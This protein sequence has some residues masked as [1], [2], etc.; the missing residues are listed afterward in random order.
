MSPKFRRLQ[1]MEGDDN[2]RAWRSHAIKKRKARDGFGA[3]HVKAKDADDGKFLVL[4]QARERML[5]EDPKRSGQED[6]T[7][8]QLPRLLLLAASAIDADHADA[9]IDA[10]VDLY[11]HASLHGHPMQR[12]MAYF[13]DGL[14]ARILTDSSPFYRSIMAHPTPEEE[15][16]A[17]TELYRASPCYQFAHFTANQTIV[18]AFEAE[19]KQNGRRLYV[20]DFD[21]SYGFQ[22]PSLIQSLCDKATTSKP[23]SL[24]LTGFGRST[25][26][27]KNTETRLVGFS[28]SCSNLEFV[29]NGLLRG[30]TTSDLKI[31]KNA[32]L[33]VNLVFY[34]QTMKSSSEMLATLMSIHSLNPSVVV[35]AEK[36]ISQRPAGY[37]AR[38][39][40]SSLNYFA[41]MFRSLHD[42]LPADSLGRL[43]IEKNHLGREI[44]SAIT[45]NCEMTSAWKGRMESTGF[46]GMKLSSRSVSQAKLLLKI[47][48]QFSSIEHVSNSGFG[49]SETDDGRTLS[50]CLQDRNL[51][52]VSA[53]KC[54][55]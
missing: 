16:T 54:T 35:L 12:V 21:V 26:E 17:F 7:D 49:I 31:E 13:A 36:E 32:T 28:K 2:V 43:S 27:L 42:C 34:L 55:R 39:V 23:I 25:E 10:I 45:C 40:E 38:F 44:K 37:S 18:E 46:Q 30:S 4:L 29:Y 53:W 48:G 3:C 50:L 41:A 5:R 11:Q 19:E 24:H 22:W 9:A 47:K 6:A 14:A 33:A 51:I 8:E 52:T 20:I 1:R 15:F